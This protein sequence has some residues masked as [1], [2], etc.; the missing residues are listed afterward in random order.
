[1]ELADSVVDPNTS[2]LDPDTEFW[3]NFDPDPGLC[4]QYIGTYIFKTI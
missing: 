3:T 1:M 4:Y 2:N